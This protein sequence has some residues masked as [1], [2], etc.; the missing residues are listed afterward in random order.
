MVDMEAGAD[1]TVEVAVV[2][3]HLPELPLSPALVVLEVMEVVLAAVPVPL[4]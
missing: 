4:P 1:T 3:V 2:V